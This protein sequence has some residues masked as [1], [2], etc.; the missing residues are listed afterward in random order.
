MVD[1]QQCLVTAWQLER[2]GPS[3]PMGKPSGQGKIE[4][5]GRFATKAL[6]ST[7]T[8]PPTSSTPCHPL[9]PVQTLLAW[10]LTVTA[11]GMT[12]T[13]VL[14]SLECNGNTFVEWR[15]FSHSTR[16]AS[17]QLGFFSERSAHQ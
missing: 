13:S 6:N 4:K 2:E 16:P 9:K 5:H 11:Q 3:K 7:P 8:P 10:L 1:M 14:C 15:M 17:H 12:S